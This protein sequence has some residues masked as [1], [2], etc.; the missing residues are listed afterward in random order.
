[1]T[2]LEKL[3]VVCAIAHDLAQALV[4]SVNQLTTGWY[5]ALRRERVAWVVLGIQPSL[6]VSRRH[7]KVSCTKA[8]LKYGCFVCR[9]G[10]F[11]ALGCEYVVPQDLGGTTTSASIP[12]Q[13]RHRNYAYGAY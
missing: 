7:V 2:T 1:M 5:I 10:F 3:S 12:F 4:L 11:V 13:A 8:F 6:L 9:V